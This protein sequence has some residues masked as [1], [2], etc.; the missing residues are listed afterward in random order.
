MLQL[1]MANWANIVTVLVVVLI[2]AAM[3]KRG[4]RKAVFHIV[5]D[6]VTT[7]EKALGSGTG[8]LKYSKAVTIISKNMPTLL[9]M[10]YT[11]EEIDNLIHKALGDLKEFL[12]QSKANLKGI[13][14]E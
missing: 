6:A 8:P 11:D 13:D 4:Y 1:I 5:L 10:F 12:R 2:L 3:Y 9:K 14:E 7:A